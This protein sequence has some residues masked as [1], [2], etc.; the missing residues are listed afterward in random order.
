L[1]KERGHHIRKDDG[2]LEGNEDE[3]WWYGITFCFVKIFHKNSCSW[4]K[5]KKYYTKKEGFVNEGRKV[6]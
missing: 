4:L 1:K 2:L 5:H 3:S 6:L